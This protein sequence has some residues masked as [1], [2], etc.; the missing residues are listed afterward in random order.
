MAVE[1]LP[2]WTLLPNWAAGM[3]ERLVWLSPVLA[4][5]SGAEQR[6]AVRQTPKRSFDLAMQAVGD[7]RQWL[8]NAL[9]TGAA[10]RWYAP[11]F[12]D[13]RHTTAEAASGGTSIPVS[14]VNAEF[15]VGGFVMLWADIWTASVHEITAVAADSLTVTPALTRTWAEG[16]LAQPC[17][18]MRIGE[19]QGFARRADRAAEGRMRWEFDGAAPYTAASLGTTYEGYPVLTVAPDEREDVTQQYAR[20]LAEFSV[21]TARRFV[22]DTADRSFTIQQQR[23]FSYGRTEQDALRGYFYALRGRAIATWVPTFMADLDLLA[24]A[25]SGATTL[26]VARSGYVRFGGPRSNRE[27]IYIELRDGTSVMRKIT[28][29]IEAGSTETLTLNSALAAD[30][31][32]DDVKRISFMSLSRLDQDSIEF[33]HHTDKSGLVTCMAAFRTAGEHRSATVYTPPAL[34]YPSQ[35]DATC[36]YDPPGP[37]WEGTLS[38]DGFLQLN[39][40]TEFSS[41]TQSYAE[42]SYLADSSSTFSIGALTAGPIRVIW[43]AASGVA[44]FPDDFTAHAFILP[45]PAGRPATSVRVLLTRGALTH[46][47]TTSNWVDTAP[48]YMSTFAGTIAGATNSF[49]HALDS[50][51]NNLSL[52][53]WQATIWLDP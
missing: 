21:E 30:L 10:L 40:A 4:S 22:V 12:P 37:D 15:A 35:S 36:G 47:F 7:E 48:N 49:V 38:V 43:H 44:F 6:F 33:T 32:V 13:R 3:T 24:N 27:H 17:A 8:D 14:T 5:P 41:G 26:S 46:D 39:D 50:G 20:L 45:F 28:G 11:I 34:A 2:L 31:A 9:T 42:A 52:D 51:F 18:V 29:A 19:M 23:W 25:A 16:T 1:D 53:T